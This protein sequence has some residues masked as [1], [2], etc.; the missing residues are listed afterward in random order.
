MTDRSRAKD[1]PNG[2]KG[3]K[4]KPELAVACMNGHMR[5]GLAEMEEHV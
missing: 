2:I 5:L 1:G 3:K 4:Q